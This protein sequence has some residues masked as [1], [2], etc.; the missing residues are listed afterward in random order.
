VR[1]GNDYFLRVQDS[2]GY[3]CFGVYTADYFGPGDWWDQTSYVFRTEPAALYCQYQFVAVQA[4][5][6]TLFGT[7]QPEY[8]QRCLA[9]AQRCFEY[10]RNHPIG[11]WKEEKLSYGLGTGAFAAALLFKATGKREYAEDARAMA[12]ELTALQ[13][14]AGFWP[15]RQGPEIP[16]TPDYNLTN[17]RYLYSAYAPLGLCTVARLLPDAPER[18]RWMAALERF[19]SSCV[20]GLAAANAFGILPTR[21]TRAS[22]PGARPWRDCYYRYF[23][24]ISQRLACPGTREIPWRTGS[25][26]TVAGYGVTILELGRL[27]ED[28]SLRALAHRQL[29]W[30]M[31]SNPSDASL[32]LGEGHNQPATY[33]SR[34]MFPTVPDIEGAVLQ[35]PIGDQVDQPLLIPGYYSSCEY[36]LPHHSWAL[37]LMAELSGDHPAGS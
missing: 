22:R 32:V 20:Q 28:A 29:D 23:T 7:P 21:I 36:W 4:L 12:N 9:A 15:E 1:W 13:H 25:T 24:D 31:G 10:C 35:G 19:A 11:D 3:A 6:A 18:A 33:P 16:I 14:R 5:I 27:L 2:R 30:V 26:A 8:A 37:W 34:E 17:A